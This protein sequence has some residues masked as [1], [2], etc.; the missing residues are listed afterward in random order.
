MLKENM[1]AMTI[2]RTNGEQDFG[3]IIDKMKKETHQHAQKE[4]A[5]F[6]KK[7]KLPRPSSKVLCIEAY[8]NILFH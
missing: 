1:N 5:K 3:E 6:I 2:E 4:F 8:E 7:D